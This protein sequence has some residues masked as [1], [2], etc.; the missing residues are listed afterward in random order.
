MTIKK[1]P[2][3]YITGGSQGSEFINQL[4][5]EILPKL[6]TFTIIHQ[7]GIA[8]FANIKEITSKLKLNNYFPVEYVDYDNIGWVL[9]NADIIIGRS[10]ANNCL[11]LHVLNKKAILIPL[12]FAQQNEQLLNAKWLQNIHPHHVIIC[13][14]ANTS[15]QVLLNSINQLHLV[16]TIFKVITP[17]AIDPLFKLIN[18]ISN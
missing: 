11:D 10:G 18:E 8:D 4:I 5:V 9:N 1:R 13:E 7:T 3:I 2:L 14:Q 6:S 16:K 15:S 17:P 12:F